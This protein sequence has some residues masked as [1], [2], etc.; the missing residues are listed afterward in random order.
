MISPDQV[1]N[2]RS[3][4]GSADNK[5]DRF[6]GFVLAD[7]LRTDRAR[8]RPLVPDSAATRALRASCRTRKDLIAHRVA[9]ANQ[10][11]EHLKGVFPG[12]IG[13]FEDLDSPISL[14]FVTRF[15]C[16]DRADWLTPTRLGNWLKSVGYT[17]RTDPAVLHARL[18]AAPRGATGTAGS[19]YTPITH[20]LLALLTTLVHQIKILDK[21]IA[22]QLAEHADAHIFTS[23]PRSGT[24]RAAKLLAEIGDCRARF[25]TPEALISLAGMA[26]ST[27]QSGKTRIVGF[28][29]SC[30]K[31]PRDA[32]TDFANDSRH[33]NPRGRRHLQPRDRPQKETP[34]RRTH[35]GPR[36][37]LRHLALLAKQHRLRPRNPPSPPSPTTTTRGLT[38]GNSEADTKEHPSRRRPM[39]RM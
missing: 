23:L 22:H 28:R 21:Q 31:N 34:P 3:R 5:D 27:R 36:L 15:D 13:L 2:L 9:V 24:V 32:V 25:P 38:Q 26:P 4:Y 14:K 33:A 6:D 19:G 29:W 35:P 7:T 16:Q 10:L 30:D 1:K 8:L 37:A 20:A 17:G 12:P 11:R 39:R 18:T